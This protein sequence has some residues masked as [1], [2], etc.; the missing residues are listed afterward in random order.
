MRAV[1]TAG[2]LNAC[3]VWLLTSLLLQ[4][5]SSGLATCLRRRV[6]VDALTSPCQRTSSYK[7]CIH[8]LSWDTCTR[9]SFSAPKLMNAP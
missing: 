6:W 8:T 3:A 1:P 5:T 4:I 7:C 9:P 2:E